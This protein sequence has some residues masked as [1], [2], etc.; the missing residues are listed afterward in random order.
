MLAAVVAVPIVLAALSPL[1]AYRSVPYTVGGFA[2]ILCLA[3]LFIQPVLAAGYLP[4]L[5]LAEARKWHRR[6]GW[7][8]VT[9]VALHIGGLYLTSPPD[10]LDALMLVAPT[11]FSV[12][13]VIA[14]WGIVLTVLLVSLRRRMGM[15]SSIWRIVHNGLALIVVVAT[16]VHALQIEGTMEPISKW[17]LCLAV[18][19]VT[20]LTLLD[21]RIVKPLLRWRSGEPGESED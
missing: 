13:G 20:S 4:G 11:P 14:L 17:A 21:L 3:V 10:T 7:A 2:G 8:I 5:R 1:L 18:L 15:R 6:A 16:V 12:Y 19:L 9:L